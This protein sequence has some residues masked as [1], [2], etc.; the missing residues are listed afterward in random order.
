MSY[1]HLQIHDVTEV[2]VDH[3]DIITR[4][5]GCAPF[6][7]ATVCLTHTGDNGQPE[8]L[9][10]VLILKAGQRLLVS[11]EDAPKARDERPEW[12]Q[13]ENET[14]GLLLDK[15]EAEVR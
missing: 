15:C 3:A 13:P 9:S 1:I 4:P 14:A 6:T 10:L 5:Y 2:T 12:V 8:K 11:L 7:S